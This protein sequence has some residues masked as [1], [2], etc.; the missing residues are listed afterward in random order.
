MSMSKM[1]NVST[2]LTMVNTYLS[3]QIFLKQFRV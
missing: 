2:Q 1:D 3:Q